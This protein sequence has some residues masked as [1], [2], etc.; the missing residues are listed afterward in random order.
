MTATKAPEE[1]QLADTLIGAPYGPAED[2]LTTLVRVAV[3]R[4]ARRLRS[5]AQAAADI[6]QSQFCVLA[7]LDR[8]GA[9][10]PGELA[11]QERVQPPSMT[12]TVA[13]LDELGFVERGPH[14]SDRRQV[15]VHLTPDGREVLTMVRRRRTAWLTEALSELDPEQR[16]AVR[17]TAELLLTMVER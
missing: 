4:T 13:A 17:E 9:L 14:P 3:Y 11:E 7:S 10:T 1:L 2:D 8:Y 15:L 12:R 16:K 6:T 5:E